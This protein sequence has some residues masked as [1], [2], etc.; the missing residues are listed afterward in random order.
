MNFRFDPMAEIEPQEPIA[1]PR[2][3]LRPASAVHSHVVVDSTLDP[4][5]PEQGPATR[6]EILIRPL[7][8]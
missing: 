7:R 4:P 5:L 3:P 2:H 1:Y 8:P 6:S